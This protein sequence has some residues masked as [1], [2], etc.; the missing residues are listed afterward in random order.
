MAEI[1]SNG[2]CEF[3]QLCYIGYE[4][5]REQTGRDAYRACPLQMQED[6]LAEIS[7]N[8][9]YSPFIEYPL[10]LYNAEVILPKLCEKYLTQE[11]I[12]YAQSNS[13]WNTKNPKIRQLVEEGELII[14]KMKKEK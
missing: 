10:E 2:E 7:K 3:E 11:M 14:E 1:E 5:Y 4:V 9:Q 6:K 13:S 8:I 12:P